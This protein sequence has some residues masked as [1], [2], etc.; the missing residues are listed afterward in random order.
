MKRGTRIEYRYAFGNVVPGKV[1]APYAA[2]MP[3]WFLCEL[4]DE[5]GKYRGGCHVSQ[6][7]VTDNRVSA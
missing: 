3:D 2:D 5:A 7:R 1:L 6:L 4:E